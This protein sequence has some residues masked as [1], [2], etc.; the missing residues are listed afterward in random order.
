MTGF[1]RAQGQF[2][3]VS[4]TWELKSV[5]ARGLDVRCRL[6]AGHE[7]LDGP[8]R[9]AATSKGLKRGNVSVALTVTRGSEAPAV[10]VNEQLLL[11]LARRMHTLQHRFPDF[12]PPRLDSLFA[13]KGVVE[14]VEEEEDD[15]A[16]DA[17]FSAM[18]TSLGHAVAGLAEMRLVEGARLAQVLTGH[19]DEIARLTA[20]AEGT[21]SL[22]PEAAR[23]RLQTLVATLLGAS[24]QLSEERLAQEA[25]LLVGKADVREELDRLKAHAGAARDLLAAG[26]PVGRK[27]DFLCQELN[28]EA[29]TLC[30]KSADVE[31]TR[32]GLD[33]KAVIE[34]FREQVQ[35]IE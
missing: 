17:R 9:E 28:R 25:A 32:L 33:L 3:A 23:E 19:L 31:L 13:V 12:A 34:Q 22:R 20:A 16:R 35:N 7:A 5:N 10:R 4:W 6:P 8:A 14:V 21:P 18:L 26:G 29:N 27:L 1:A 15:E 2:G 11:E 30:S 24:P